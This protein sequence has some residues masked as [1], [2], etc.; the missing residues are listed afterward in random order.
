MRPRR[1][2]RRAQVRKRANG[3]RLER[4][5]LRGSD[6]ADRLRSCVRACMH[7]CVK[8][9]WAG[10]IGGKAKN[11]R[12]CC[13]WCPHSARQMASVCERAPAQVTAASYHH[14]R[15]PCRPSLISTPRLGRRTVSSPL[16]R[17]DFG[18]L[19][20][21]Y[22]IRRAVTMICTHA[23][24]PCA[25]IRQLGR[26]RSML[27]QTS[28]LRTSDMVGSIGRAREK[29]AARGCQRRH[30]ASAGSPSCLSC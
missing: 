18:Q 12:G 8:A 22:V 14:D 19:K 5:R 2:G 6:R 15:A 23:R 17:T 20:R 11:C 21:L 4:V 27:A 25:P 30:F 16:A 1:Q 26:R 7:A 13:C 9:I 29:S 28:E 24:R 3:G 10:Q